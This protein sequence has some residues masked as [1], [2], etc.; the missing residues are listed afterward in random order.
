MDPST[1]PSH[2]ES[3]ATWDS[4]QGGILHHIVDIRC[5]LRIFLRID[6]N[7]HGFHGPLQYTKSSLTQGTRDSRGCSCPPRSLLPSILQ[8]RTALGPHRCWQ[9]S[10][11]SSPTQ[12]LRTTL[13]TD[14][15]NHQAFRAAIPTHLP[16]GH[17]DPNRLSP[18]FH[19]SKEPEQTGHAAEGVGA[20]RTPGPRASSAVGRAAPGRARSR[21]SESNVQADRLALRL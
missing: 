21:T 20:S 3:P 16:P 11:L 9:P 8:G 1:C 19:Q 13:E 5:V 10:A 7:L 18:Y 4:Y 14:C 15:G 17:R 6:I 12:V 2:Q